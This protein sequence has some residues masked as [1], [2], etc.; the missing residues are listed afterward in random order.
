MP[1][2][3]LEENKRVFSRSSLIHQTSLFQYLRGLTTDQLNIVLQ[4]SLP[5]IHLIPYPDSAGGASLRKLDTATELM[6]VLAVCR[7]RL[8]QGFIE[9]MVG[10]SKATI[11]R[12]FI[13]WIIFLA[14]LFNEIEL[15][16]RISIVSLR[17]QFECGKMRTRITVNRLT[18][19]K[20]RKNPITNCNN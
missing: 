7:H 10:L 16:L 15:S 2:K 9:F 18:Y 1:H 12:I 19:Y 11:E 17:I 13:G 14:T 8:H 3:L 20:L 5:Y 6:A 4:W